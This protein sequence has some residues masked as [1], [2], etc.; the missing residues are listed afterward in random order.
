MK[1]ILIIDGLIKDIDIIKKSINKNTQ[2]YTYS[3]IKS[4]S[5]IDEL[6]SL[7]YSHINHIGFLYHNDY[8]SLPVD[9]FRTKES[10]I[11][12]DGEPIYNDNIFSEGFKTYLQLVILQNPH[13]I[14]DLLT[15]NVND[16]KILDEIYTM[17]NNYNIT[18]RYSTDEKGNV[19]DGNWI[20]ESHNINI[21][22]IYFTDYILNWK[23]NLARE[24]Y[25]IEDFLLEDNP[26]FYKVR[27]F[28]Y[29]RLLYYINPLDTDSY[30]GG[31]TIT[32]LVDNKKST[33]SN[34]NF[35][36]N[37]GIQ[38]NNSGSNGGL[39]IDNLQ[40]AKYIIM[41]IKHIGNN[42]F[43]LD[44]RNSIT[45]D[46]SYISYTTN[47]NDFTDQNI[48]YDFNTSTTSQSTIQTNIINSD[49]NWKLIS[50]AFKNT[51]DKI[52][53]FNNFSLDSGINI[54]FGPIKIFNDYITFLDHLNNYS[55]YSKLLTPANYENDSN[56]TLIYHIDPMDTDSYT[57]G[58]TITNL[59]DDTNNT[60]IN[61]NYLFDENDNGI[62]LFKDGY[63]SNQ[64]STSY[65]NITGLTNAK[66]ISFWFKY[67][68]T[69]GDAYNKCLIDTTNNGGTF[70]FIKSYTPSIQN[71][72]YLFVNGQIYRSDGVS[73]DFFYTPASGDPT[74]G[75]TKYHTVNGQPVEAGWFCVSIVLSDGFNMSDL[76]LFNSTALNSGPNVIM[77]PIKIYDSFISFQEHIDFYNQ[78]SSR[79]ELN[80]IEPDITGLQHRF[81]DVFYLKKDITWNSDIG[82]IEDSTDRILLSAN[83]V[84]DGNGHTITIPSD[85]ISYG[86]MI[87]TT[88]TG[89]NNIDNAP[90]IRNLKVKWTRNWQAYPNLIAK[91]SGGIARGK[92]LKITK[93]STDGFIPGNSGGIIGWASGQSGGFII[94]EN[95]FSDCLIV[96]NIYS[97]AVYFGTGMIVSGSCCSYDGIC[98]IRN[99]YSTN[100]NITII[101]SGGISGGQFVSPYK[102]IIENC[103]S[104]G[105]LRDAESGLSRY[106][107]C[108]G[109]IGSTLTN[110][111]ELCEINNCF[112]LA[113]KDFGTYKN[114]YPGICGWNVENLRTTNCYCLTSN[115]FGFSGNY[116]NDEPKATNSF[117][118]YEYYFLNEFISRDEIYIYDGGIRKITNLDGTPSTKLAPSEY[119]LGGEVDRIYAYCQY[120]L[121]FN[122]SDDYDPPLN[123]PRS[124]DQIPK[125]LYHMT[126]RNSI[127]YNYG[128]PEN[129]LKNTFV[130]YDSDIDTYPGAP[131][132]FFKVNERYN[133]DTDKL[134]S[135][136][137]DDYLINNL[138]TEW[139]D[140]IW[141]PQEND[142]PRLKIFNDDKKSIWKINNHSSYNYEFIYQQR[143]IRDSLFNILFLESITLSDN[144]IIPANTYFNI[145]SDERQPISWI[146]KYINSDSINI[147]DNIDISDKFVSIDDTIYFSNSGF[148]FH[149]LNKVYS[150][151]SL[152]S[153]ELENDGKIFKIS[154]DF[155]NDL[156]GGGSISFVR[157]SDPERNE[158]PTTI[159]N[160]ISLKDGTIISSDTILNF[161]KN[162]LY[163]EQWIQTYNN[164]NSFDLSS[165][166][167]NLENYFQNKNDKLYFSNGSNNFYAFGNEFN[168]DSITSNEI[169]YNDKIYNISVDFNGGSGGG[170]I[171]YIADVIN[172][173]TKL[174]IFT[175]FQTTIIY[176]DDT[177][178]LIN[179]ITETQ[180]LFDV[181]FKFE[182]LDENNIYFSYININP[183]ELNLDVED[184]NNI[185][186]INQIENYIGQY[187][188]NNTTNKY[189]FGAYSIS[190]KFI[191]GKYYVNFYD[192]TFKDN[193]YP[194]YS[195]DSI[196]LEYNND[197]NY[198]I[199]YITNEYLNEIDSIN[200][201]K[202]KFIKI[203]SY[204]TDTIDRY[205]VVHKNLPTGI[206]TEDILLEG[207]DTGDDKK[208]TQ[209]NDPDNLIL[210][211]DLPTFTNNSESQQINDNNI[212]I[213]FKLPPEYIPLVE[214]VSIFNTNDRKIGNMSISSDN[215][216]YFYILNTDEL[217]IYIDKLTPFKFTFI[218]KKI[219]Q[220]KT[221]NINSPYIVNNLNKQIYQNTNNNT[222][223]HTLKIRENVFNNISI[224]ENDIITLDFKNNSESN[225]FNTILPSITNNFCNLFLKITFTNSSEILYPYIDTIYIPEFYS[226][227][228][229]ISINHLLKY[230]PS[231][232]Q[233]LNSLIKNE[234][235]LVTQHINFNDNTNNTYYTKLTFTTNIDNLRKDIYNKELEVRFYNQ[236]LILQQITPQQKDYIIFFKKST[237]STTFNIKNL[238]SNITQNDIIKAYL[239][240]NYSFKTTITTRRGRRVSVNYY[241]NYTFYFN[242]NVLDDNISIED[243]FNYDSNGY[244]FNIFENISSNNTIY[245]IITNDFFIDNFNLSS[246]SSFENEILKY[247]S[248]DSD[249]YKL[250]QDIGWF[251]EGKDLTFSQE[252]QN[253]IEN[254]TDFVSGAIPVDEANT[255]SEDTLINNTNPTNNSTNIIGS[256][257][258]MVF[259]FTDINGTSVTL[260]ISNSGD[261]FTTSNYIYKTN[262]FGIGS[263][264][265][266]VKINYTIDN[267]LIDNYTNSIPINDNYEFSQEALRLYSINPF[268]IIFIDGDNNETDLTDIITRDD[269]NIYYQLLIFDEAEIFL[270]LEH[271]KKYTVKIIQS[272]KDNI[273]FNLT[274]TVNKEYHVNEGYTSDLITFKNTLKINLFLYRIYL[275]NY[276]L[277]DTMQYLFDNYTVKY[278]D[279]IDLKTNITDCIFITNDDHI[280]YY[281]NHISLKNI[282]N[283]TI[284]YN[285]RGKTTTI[286]GLAYGGSG[287]GII[288]I[289]NLI[290]CFT[291]DTKV[292]TPMGYRYIKDFEEGDLVKTDKGQIVPVDKIMI[293]YSKSSNDKPYLIPKNFYGSLPTDDIYIS[294]LHVYKI[295]DKWTRAK[296]EKNLQQ[297]TLTDTITYYNLKLPD[298]NKHN[299]V[300]SGIVCESWND[301]SDNKHSMWVKDRKHNMKKITL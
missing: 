19:K 54:V 15:C 94:V 42:D 187:T 160:N 179:N 157:F 43:L 105:V 208:F 101:R 71:I 232:T 300:C 1:N 53:L 234:I 162:E 204:Q 259:T 284:T 10:E 55:F 26:I 192:I 12:D 138:P 219:S 50:I 246:G 183:N 158:Y 218:I 262:T 165:N 48:F 155:Y 97:Q 115:L 224:H 269:A 196:L 253:S 36:S 90:I 265:T 278:Y 298:H 144:T 252:S 189:E 122:P 172:N 281:G 239:P 142:Y 87:H 260:N 99:C 49:N 112:V 266:Q 293:R 240:N 76:I 236:N 190:F 135:T 230:I 185:N 301:F 110:P 170:S 31:N 111:T 149:F 134:F 225:D 125:D 203:H 27:E 209:H 16:I 186:I 212:K 80:S 288:T 124:L 25:D 119:L 56:T 38:L 154:I 45:D 21:K 89:V 176:G 198:Y 133:I 60:T 206:I 254:I 2:L 226:S 241:Y 184:S 75:Y 243:A 201:D 108:G 207:V 264:L 233:T 200:D 146:N 270:Y 47:S 29:T 285:I 217:P 129:R 261:V 66:T 237:T 18:I 215:S 263:L 13:I 275:N 100:N 292:L 131:V 68:Q 127:P 197:N 74:D 82:V 102:V 6:H 299:L 11:N 213:I 30:N 159:E 69:P 24:K 205:W 46:N 181:L 287:I 23:H 147:K 67:L 35:I 120:L 118:N 51:F 267:Y 268:E 132:P 93:C 188:Y 286:T 4:Q 289:A 114:W 148:T 81:K 274:L 8:N 64:L 79:Y 228:Y 171:E 238:Y 223:N 229:N 247:T 277:P 250:L 214:Q 72:Q 128:I 39:V 191:D 235:F 150:F 272:G 59:I 271:N 242:N 106:N 249:T 65:L 166:I 73:R 168:F 61:N 86:T 222:A 44:T 57:G 279:D 123:E 84:L 143:F 220:T 256:Q 290:P 296:Y 140:T 244:T 17:Q 195:D 199:N 34:Y 156:C 3:F 202:Q 70:P 151:N 62:R 136:N 113:G 14:I 96:P 193:I 98:I 92:F 77:G 182:A 116:T 121:Q 174:P 231:N 58:T 295:N 139:D 109:I 169:I 28:T 104:I 283:K 163:P 255:I 117:S 273:L 221:I 164:I 137:K 5:I 33:I 22:N 245:N 41:W 276:T 167:P 78:Y 126:F 173:S 20:Q 52:T 178:K 107:V 211:D 280:Y 180:T 141:D 7:D 177:V 294:P 63:P 257:N 210:L 130:G 32:N 88:G 248:P 161:V 83:Q 95:C 37:Q 152:Y 40:N 282:F 297:V 216:Y 258:N 291:G 145:I 175:N 103:F 91:Y 85:T 251:D 194:S 153:I 227:N 9:F